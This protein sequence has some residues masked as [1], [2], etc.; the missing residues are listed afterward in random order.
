MQLEEEAR[1]DPALALDLGALLAARLAAAVALRR[2]LGL[3]S[4]DTT[5]YR[6]VNRCPRS[7]LQNRSLVDSGLLHPSSQ[8]SMHPC[9]NS[10]HLHGCRAQAMSTMASG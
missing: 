2:V 9:V 3:P 7:C 1:R 4:P 8:Q 5:V 10:L 6:L